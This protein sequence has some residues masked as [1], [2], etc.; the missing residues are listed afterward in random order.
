MSVGSV[1]F[2]MGRGTTEP[3]TLGVPLVYGLPDVDD[4]LDD[5][6]IGSALG[7]ETYE[8]KE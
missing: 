2:E 8:A 7:K 1:G 4:F 6:L 3:G 5:R